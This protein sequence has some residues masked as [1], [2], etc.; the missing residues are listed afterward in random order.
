MKKYLKTHGYIIVQFSHLVVSIWIYRIQFYLCEWSNIKL[1]VYDG[2]KKKPK[3]NHLYSDYSKV[4]WMMGHSALLDNTWWNYLEQVSLFHFI[5]IH[6]YKLPAQ[7]NTANREFLFV[8][9]IVA[10]GTNMQETI[11]IFK[12]MDMYNSI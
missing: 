6:Y 7:S 3:E 10:N 2:K 8:I 9:G 11:C 4:I 5:N 12:C 1:T